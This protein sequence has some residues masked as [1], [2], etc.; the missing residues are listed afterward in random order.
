MICRVFSDYLAFVDGVVSERFERQFNSVRQKCV[1]WPILLTAPIVWKSHG[2]APEHP[3]AMHVLLRVLHLYST[4]L[5]G[6]SKGVL[7][8]LVGN[9][10][11]LNRLRFGTDP[12]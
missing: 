5:N 7:P 2:S 4:C 8:M 3:C 9:W 6:F 10:D 1:L 12:S 11:G